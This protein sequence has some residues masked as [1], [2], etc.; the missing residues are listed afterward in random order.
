MEPEGLTMTKRDQWK[1]ISHVRI[2]NDVLK[3][4][5]WAALSPSARGLYADLRTWMFTSTNGDISA[6][7]SNLRPLGYK[8]TTLTKYLYELQAA[9]LIAKTR[10]GGVA[11]GSKVCALYRFTDWPVIGVEKKGIANC[12]ATFDYRRFATVDD[13]RAGIKASI[14]AMKADAKVRTEK[15]GRDR[16]CPSEFSQ[17][18]GICPSGD[19]A[20]TESVLVDG[21]Q[22]NQQAHASKWFE[23]ITHEDNPTP[24]TGTESVLLSNYQG[25]GAFTGSGSAQQS[26]LSIMRHGRYA[27]MASVTSGYRNPVRSITTNPNKT[28]H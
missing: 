18:D 26:T 10:A 6:A 28:F 12:K 15:K 3:S 19:F 21:T 23:P 2:M 8:H 25:M 22:N 14:E 11:R 16:I 13:A 7:L 1:G 20:G 5:A 4:P 17:R 24:I 9:G 27:Q